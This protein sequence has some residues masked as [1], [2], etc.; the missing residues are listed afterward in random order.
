MGQKTSASLA[1]RLAR[2]WGTPRGKVFVGGPILALCLILILVTAGLRVTGAF[3]FLQQSTASALPTGPT[4]V[5]EEA[6]MYSL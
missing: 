1:A 2:S 3:P 5:L 4:Q 6:F